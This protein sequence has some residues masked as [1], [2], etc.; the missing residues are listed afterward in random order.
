MTRSA[1]SVP[2]TMPTNDTTETSASSTSI[3]NPETTNTE[4]HVDADSIENDTDGMLDG[5]DTLRRVVF[6]MFN[7]I[8]FAY[9]KLAKELFTGCPC[10]RS[11]CRRR[12]R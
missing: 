10:T 1:L 9:A 7:F 12:D 4:V 3:S 5:N 11:A 8:G 6:F 2:A